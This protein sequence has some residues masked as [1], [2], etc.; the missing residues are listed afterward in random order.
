M[1]PGTWLL[2]P[3]DAPRSRFAPLGVVVLLAASMVVRLL[4]RKHGE[5]LNKTAELVA[6]CVATLFPALGQVWPPVAGMLQRAM[7]AVAYL[8]FAFEA[9]TVARRR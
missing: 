3:W 7:F 9:L 4:Q 2:E 1:Q 8:W 5:S 6:I